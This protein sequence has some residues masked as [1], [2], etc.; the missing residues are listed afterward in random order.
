MVCSHFKPNVYRF[1]IPIEIDN[2]GFPCGF[3]DPTM[4]LV[5]NHCFMLWILRFAI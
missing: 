2:A 3:A 4:S 5:G 1:Q